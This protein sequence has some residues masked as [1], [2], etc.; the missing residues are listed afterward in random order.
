[1]YAKLHAA[2]QPGTRMQVLERM[3]TR[4]EEEQQAQAEAEAAADGPIV[5]RGGSTGDAADARG[6]AH[7]LLGVLQPAA[8]AAPAGIS[9]SVAPVAHMDE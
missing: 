7:E 8:A 6:V 9:P 3:P 4:A 1:M 2:Q 5:Q